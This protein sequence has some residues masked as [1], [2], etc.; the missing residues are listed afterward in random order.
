M[1]YRKLLSF[2]MAVLF[3][4]SCQ[5]DQEVKL[6]PYNFKSEIGRF[7]NLEFIA[8]EDV[9]IDT[10]LNKWIEAE[11]IAFDPPVNGRFKYLNKRSILFS[12]TEGFAPATSY[13]MNLGKIP[14]E[15][16]FK[17]LLEAEEIHTPGFKMERAQASWS[18][19]TNGDLEVVSSLMFNYP[20]SSDALVKHLE[21]YDEDQKIEYKL[22]SVSQSKDLIIHIL[23][24]DWDVSRSHKLKFKLA[25]SF[26][27]PGTATNLAKEL[28][29]Y[30]SVPARERF[31][32]TEMRTDFQKESGVIMVYT[33][34]PVFQDA[35]KMVGLIE[36]TPELSWNIEKHGQGFKIVGAFE[37]GK[38]YQVKI[39]KGLK[40]EFDRFLDEDYMKSVSFGQKEPYLAVGDN[41]GYYLSSKGERNLGFTM[42][43]IPEI[44]VTVFKVFENN[45]LQYFKNGKSWDY[46]YTDGDYHS[47]HSY[48]LD[49]NYGKLIYKEKINTERLEGKG[50][51]RYLN[52][53]LEKI[54]YQ[55]K[56]KGI[57][58]VKVAS[59][60]KQWLKEIQMVSLSDI[61]LI[62]KQ[63]KNKLFVFTN[64]IHDTKP[65]SDVNIELVSTN[66]QKIIS[67]QT[68]AQG[69]AEFDDLK[70]QLQ[71]FEVGMITAS[72][73][74]DYNFLMLN[75]TRIQT[76]RYDVGG[77]YINDQNYDVFVYGDRDLYRPADS[78][79][80]NIIARTQHWETIKDLPLKI[81][82]I[83]PNGKLLYQFRKQL[84]DFGAVSS[85][86]H[87]PADV[88]TGRFNVEVFSAND[89]LLQNYSFM[90]EEFMPD[91]IS[92]KASVDRDTFKPSEDV[93]LELLAM[94]L[95]GTPAA[96]RN[97]EVELVLN[98][99]QFS[100]PDYKAYS[101]D[102]SLAKEQRFE[103]SMRE[104]KTDSE[105]EAELLFVLPEYKNVGR[106][107]GKLFS[108]V[109]DE[110]GRPV[111]RQSSFDV[112]TQDIF[113]GIRNFDRY[114][115]TRK[116]LHIPVIA[117]DSKGDLLQT[118]DAK[119]EV[120]KIDWETVIEQRGSGY[121]YR[122]QQ[123]KKL[124]SSQTLK[125]KGLNTMIDFTPMISGQYEIFLKLPEA[126]SYVKK[127]F[128]AYGWGDT[129]YS[130]FEVDREGRVEVDFDKTEY[131]IGETAQILFKAPYDGR[132]LVT[133]EQD[134]VLEYHYLDTDNK[135]AMLNLSLNK[136]HMP[137]VYVSATAIRKMDG[138][139]LPLT[140]AHGYGTAAVQNQEKKIDVNI[141]APEKVRSKSKQTV[142]V[143]AKP[144]SKMSIA[145]VDEG[146][147]QINAFQTPDPY[148]YFYQ[149]RAL[150]VR[151]FD[152]YEY[153]LPDLVS[154]SSSASGG[155]GYDMSKRVNPFANERVKLIAKWS[156]IVEA[157]SK[158]E[159]EYSFEI[160][161]FSG[162]LRVMA[163]CWDKDDFGTSSKQIKVA[164]P[165]VMSAA[166]PRFMSPGD[167]V[168][169]PVILSNTTDQEDEIDVKLEISEGIEIIGENHQTV[170]VSPKGETQAQFWLKAG[171]NA[172]MTEIKILA[173]AFDEVF[174]DQINITIRP[175][176]GLQ[177]YSQEGIVNSKKTDTL[178]T[179]YDLI[180]STRS[181]KFLLSSNPMIEMVG[182]LKELIGY[183]YGCLE[184]T[185][186]KAFP[187]IYIKD[188]M[189]S[190]GL[191]IPGQNPDY[192]VQQAIYKVQGMQRYD[193]SFSYWSGGYYQNWW[194]TVYA[195]HFLMEAESAGFEVSHPVLSKAKDFIRKEAKN[196][197]KESYHY[198]DRQTKTYY[199]NERTSREVF[200]SLFLQALDGKADRSL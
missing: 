88:M 55:N 161:R 26:V 44:E 116:E 186:S 140:I 48:P 38:T 95:Y 85:S 76:S 179:D 164:D 83:A 133:V 86:I 9:F 143:K 110:T 176:A 84:D 16:N 146:I 73:L 59:L 103:R 180:P 11:I 60:K 43:N 75:R 22:E 170:T 52:L 10:L 109:F 105:G 189:K 141:I 13:E 40:G 155:A 151:S 96:N 156:G 5:E 135:A 108:T 32:I 63:G 111:N 125:I 6:K 142:K 171:E 72:K 195:T 107:Q 160:P 62:V 7:Q 45:L 134:D 36:I 113:L 165:L 178:K 154:R 188:L 56:F 153:L 53:D 33:S 27:Y 61:G 150:S 12:P 31:M 94:N 79:H 119:V 67:A 199:T 64:S 190:A 200:Y 80:F 139:S 123:K 93:T 175:T 132:L 102:I 191:E 117:V 74:D 197:S 129:D 148:S 99:T 137:N 91:R 8:T 28:S 147:L 66:N 92:V 24:D 167:Q 90:V 185:T 162:A 82:V 196:K 29:I 182:E 71:G 193:G 49:N 41:S 46:H 35:S 159:Y 127:R 192:F 47:S 78:V 30:A 89:V 163:V 70:N 158:G 37:D 51:V 50:N 25:T 14:I 181:S 58:L 169:M 145:V 81:K 54:D 184:Q 183:P 1:K 126:S 122:S 21:I 138:S 19:N 23:A 177:K 118:A 57:Y 101:F 152:L 115:D 97:Y 173:M 128:Y 149:K 112:Y 69:V 104:G 121:Y 17:L 100:A 168:L 198:Y 4:I 120:W 136:K 130:S 174:D 3:L 144:G 114:V 131:N 124:I 15:G 187:Q 106:V 42:I 87:I 68:N 77:K 98:R 2:L 20:I 157:N 18:K 166:L 172:G 39:D 34:Q 194:A 65:L